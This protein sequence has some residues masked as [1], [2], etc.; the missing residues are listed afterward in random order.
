[1]TYDVLLGA[2]SS[3]EILFANVCVTRRNGNDEFSA[4][5]FSVMP[6]DSGNIDL[7]EY[8]DNTIYELD[9]DTL[10]SLLEE[11]DCKLSQLSSCLAN[12]MGIDGTIGCS[13]YPHTY[14]INGTEWYFEDRLFGQHDFRNEMKEVVDQ[15]MM[16]KIYNMWEEYHL[17]EIDKSMVREVSAIED[18]ANKIDNDAWIVGFISRHISEF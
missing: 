7:V 2:T 1:M 5:F 3:N 15:D 11:Y 9:A 12:D 6:F 8:W 10:R 16:N 18:A 13:M 14:N 17:R 4:H